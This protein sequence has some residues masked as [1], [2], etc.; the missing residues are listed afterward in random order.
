MV[1]R[2]HLLYELLQK[3]VKW[4][5]TLEHQTQ[6]DHIKQIFTECNRNHIFNPKEE[7]FISRDASPYGI[8]VKLCNKDS[9]GKF[10]TVA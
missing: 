7:I 8:G 6:F 3:N 4:N 5:W 1:T 10:K 2:P 9:K